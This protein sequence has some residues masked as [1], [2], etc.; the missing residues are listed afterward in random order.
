[1]AAQAK[2]YVYH[3]I[4]PR[5]NNVFYVGK[6][7]GD[8]IGYHEREAETRSGSSK[9]DQI[10]SIW[11]EGF[12]VVRAKVAYFFDEGDAYDFERGQIKS[13][14]ELTNV[15]CGKGRPLPKV[16]SFFDI[17]SKIMNAISDKRSGK[18]PDIKSLYSSLRR[19]KHILPARDYR[20]LYCVAEKG[21]LLWL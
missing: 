5:T 11:K 12:E 20:D 7:C 3:L 21:C 13:L 9:V 2:W 16:L 1:M 4:D 6:G 17:I 18:N 14:P 15:K 8:R 10:R 19:F